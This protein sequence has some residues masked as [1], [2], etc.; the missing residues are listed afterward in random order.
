MKYLVTGGAGF[1]GSNLCRRLLDQGN[2]VSCL[3]DLSTGRF[4][5]IEELESNPNFEFFN[6]DL[7]KP[8][9][10][11]SIDAIFNL[12][13]PASPVHYQYNPIRTL[14]MGTLAMYN[15]L[16]MASRLKVP[17]LQASTSEIYG[18][19]SEHPQTES[20]LGNVN[21]IGPRAC[22]DEGKRVAEALCVAY[23]SYNEVQIRI[24]RIFNTYGPFMDPKDGRVVSNFI[25]QSIRNEELTVYGDGSQTRSFC[26]VDD[27]V[28]GLIR[29]LHSD[30]SKPVNLG[31]PEEY[32]MI[33]FANIVRKLTSSNSEVKFLDLPADDPKKRCPD[34]S[35]AS[36]I[37]DWKPQIRLVEG[38]KSTIKWYR[39]VLDE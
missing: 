39:K 18:D 13:C 28:D 33:D 10:P 2:S 34:I 14:K 9:F 3:D 23:E 38:L 7:T 27:L 35:L 32:S 30:Y 20:Y 5:N 8:F 31:N 17:I 11:D 26:Y 22:Y 29:L 12:A 6:H 25:V 19:P 24:A 4:R 15:V 1:I 16:G 21:P 37:L 36:N